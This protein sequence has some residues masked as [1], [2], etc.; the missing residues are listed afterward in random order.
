MVQ[1]KQLDFSGQKI[2]CGIDVHKKSWKVCIRSE[3]MVLKTFS[4][5]PSVG[6]LVRHLR[7]NYPSAD[8]RVTYEAGFSGFSAQRAFKEENV[9][10][11]IVHPADV[12]TTDK[13]KQR[14]SDVVDCRKL[15]E[16]LSDGK[17]TAIYVPSIEQQDDR[18]VIRAY[19]QFVKDQTRCKN[20]IKSWLAFQGISIPGDDQYKHWSNNFIKWLRNLSLTP[21]ARISLDMLI[22]S[23]EH[24][25][26]MVLTATK[27]V[28]ALSKQQRYKEQIKLIRSIPGIGE[29]AGLLFTTEIGDITRFKKFDQL[30][31]FIGLVPKVNGS[32]DRETVLGL[33]HRGHHKLRETLME[34]SWVAIRLDPAMTMFF[35]EC[36]KRMQKNKAIIKVARKMLNRIRCV[37]KNKTEYVTGVVE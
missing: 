4:Q 13:E 11:I 20:R 34:A 26:S 18:S 28:R 27:Q 35:N 17:L 6:E 30:C 2:F 21:S 9:N 19:L 37:M 14:K 12:P 22:Q 36:A 1:S 32:G 8:Y 7:K 31:D 33:T 3:H 15:S 5:N 29:I 24:T 23:Y 10:C 16:S 25:R